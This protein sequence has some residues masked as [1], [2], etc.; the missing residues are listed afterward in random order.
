M[1]L[2]TVG[3]DFCFGNLGRKYR[4]GLNI[5]PGSLLQSSGMCDGLRIAS[6]ITYGVK[7]C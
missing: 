1:W 4:S 3:D 7:N 2:V 5:T 6:E